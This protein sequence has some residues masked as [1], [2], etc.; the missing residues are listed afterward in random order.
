MLLEVPWLVYTSNVSVRN[1]KNL[2]LFSPILKKKFSYKC[3]KKLTNFAI[4]QILAMFPHIAAER[5]F[6]E[7]IKLAK[8]GKFLYYLI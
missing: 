8:H 4:L 7:V 6:P 1:H 5:Y 2:A 3:L